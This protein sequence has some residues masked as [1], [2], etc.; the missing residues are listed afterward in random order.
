MCSTIG[1]LCRIASMSVYVE[2]ASVYFWY[3]MT[4][5]CDSIDLGSEYPA[6]SEGRTFDSSTEV[7]G[8]HMH[9][10]GAF[11]TTFKCRVSLNVFAQVL[12]KAF[13]HCLHK[14][15]YPKQCLLWQILC[16][17]LRYTCFYPHFLAN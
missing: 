7:Q 12:P 2:K 15:Y 8:R 11:V 14:L 4:E 3:F 10:A 6:S 13:K 1:G 9:S 17:K 16:V 5:K